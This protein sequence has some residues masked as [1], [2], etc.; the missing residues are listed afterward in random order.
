MLVNRSAGDLS[1]DPAALVRSAAPRLAWAPT[2]SRTE[3]PGLRPARHSPLAACLQPHN[4]PKFLGIIYLT[5]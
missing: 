5:P 4:D 1:S 2:S 3:R